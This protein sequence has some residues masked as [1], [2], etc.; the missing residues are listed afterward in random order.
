MS[1]SAEQLDRARGAVLGSGVGDALGAAYEFGC[2]AVGPEGPEMLGGGLGGFEPG[3]WTDD[4]AMAWCIL[5]VAATRADLG[6]DAALTE[7][8]HRFREWYDGGPADI[9]NQT[10]AVLGAAGEAPSAGALTQAAHD[11]HAQTGRSA[12]NG[13]LMRTA[14]VALRFLDDPEAL[15][16]AARRI[17]A[18]THVDQQAQDACV[19]WSAAIAQAIVEGEFDVR[20]GLALL[21]PA[22]AESWAELIDAA[23][24]EDPATFQPNGWV[25]TAFQAAWSAIAQT[26]V[27]AQDPRQHFSVAL[28]TV[29][30]IGDDTDTTAA[31]AGA[32]LGAKWGAS[33]VPQRWRRVLHGYPGIAADELSRLVD[34]AVG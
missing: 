32:L 20:T 24:S 26:P 27:P 21:A 33:A 10:R 17:S 6:S 7:I 28:D 29:I 1:L 3:E 23:E 25:V 18:L 34:L 11:L 8:A 2:A 13:S 9:G 16:A 22:Q 4:T 30:R 15:A 12:G 19:L 5:D 31:I 14:P